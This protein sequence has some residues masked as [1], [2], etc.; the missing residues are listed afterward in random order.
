MRISGI[1][2]DAIAAKCINDFVRCDCAN[3]EIA[4]TSPEFG[5]TIVKCYC[6]FKV[7]CPDSIFF[8]FL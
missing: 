2:I 7:T 4:N 5:L 8:W 1:K 6:G 3:R